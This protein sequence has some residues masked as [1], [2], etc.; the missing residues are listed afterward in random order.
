MKLGFIGF[1]EAA[2]E[3]AQGLSKEGLQQIEAFDY[4]WDDPV[5]GPLI[6]ERANEASVHLQESMEAVAANSDMIIVAVP[7]DK[8]YSVCQSLLPFL[9]DKQLYVDVSAASPEIKAA[10]CKSL[11]VK[12]IQ[13]VDIAMMGPL[14]V[15]KHKV[16]MLASGLGA[17]TFIRLTG[18]YGMDVTKISDFAGEASATKLI[19]SIFMKGISTLLVEMLTA[20]KHYNVDEQ[21]IHSIAETMNKSDFETTM[22]RLV[23]GT[24]IHSA[25]RS[26]ELDGT[27]KM[28][29]D[30]HLS[31]KMSR[32]TKGTLDAITN[33]N[34]RD[35]FKAVK[36]DSW[37]EVI[38]A[39]ND[40]VNKREEIDV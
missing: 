13:F 39:I 37:L 15:Y 21:V 12:N 4:L 34:L 26:S 29:Q 18:Q 16:P 35:S 38:L 36:P 6:K 2:Y 3:M 14:S 32:A 31:S 20:A 23:T 8:T 5:F 19:R 25:R 40:K 27:I 11:E 28:L 10:V 33:L 24:A 30:A 1:G 9:S 7:A 17:D 22:N